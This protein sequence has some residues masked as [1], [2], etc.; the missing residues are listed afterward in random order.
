[1]EKKFYTTSEMQELGFS[2][3]ELTCARNVPGQTYATQRT[4]GSKWYWDLE[5]FE[6]A[7]MRQTRKRRPA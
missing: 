2:A 6:A 1:M 4:P 3:H 7:R 5:K